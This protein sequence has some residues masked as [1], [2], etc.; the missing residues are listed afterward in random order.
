M[1]KDRLR[2]L[3]KTQSGLTQAK[4]AKYLGIAKTTYASYE[5][6]NRMPD[7]EIQK[8]I[9]D[10]FNVSLEYLHGRPNDLDTLSKKQVSVASRVTEDLTDYQLTEIITFIEFIKNRPE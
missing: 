10:Y 3:R 9:A 1:L 8:E 7:I 2:Q 5:Q 4:M 6:G